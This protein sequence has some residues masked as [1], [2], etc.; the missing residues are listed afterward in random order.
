MKLP[1]ASDRAI[2]KTAEANGCK[3]FWHDGILGWRYHCDCEDGTHCCDQQC[4]TITKKSAGRRA[5]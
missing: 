5:N 2:K 4:S 1:N 3:P